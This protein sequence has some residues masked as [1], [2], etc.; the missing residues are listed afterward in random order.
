MSDRMFGDPLEDEFYTAFVRVG[1][2]F[3]SAGSTKLLK[4][5]A[6]LREEVPTDIQS[7]IDTLQNAESASMHRRYMTILLSKVSE[8]LKDGAYRPRIEEVCRRAIAASNVSGA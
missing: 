7:L 1:I 6:E 5:L 3:G 8:M 2:R 4:V